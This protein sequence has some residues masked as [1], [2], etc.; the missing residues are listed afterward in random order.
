MNKA[1]RLA[2]V[3]AGIVVLVAGIVWFSNKNNPSSSGGS[4]NSGKSSS[5]N[6]SNN[7]NTNAAATITYDG[8][9]FEP[10][11]ITI[12]KGQTIKIVN[13]SS[14]AQLSFASDP[15]PTHT[16][17]PE[18]NIGSIDPG[19]S[20]DVTVTKVGTWGYHNH[21]NPSQAGKITVTD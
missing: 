16:N 2:I 5:S 8:S 12:K 4:T 9:S 14:S 6:S 7:T 13:Q 19:V 11:N 1:M 10:N 3:L 18:L 17:E 21:F 20:A 15:H